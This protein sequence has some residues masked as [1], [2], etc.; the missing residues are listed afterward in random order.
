MNK[1]ILK[2]IIVQND[3]K[4]FDNSVYIDFK[5]K[6]IVTILKKMGI[7]NELIY[8][9]N[10]FAGISINKKIDNNTFQTI[11]ILL[12]SHLN[13]TFNSKIL[14]GKIL[15]YGRNM[16]IY[17]NLK[18]NIFELNDKSYINHDELFYYLISNESILPIVILPETVELLQKSGWY[19]GRKI[20]IEEFIMNYDNELLTDN[21]IYF[22]QEFGGIKGFSVSGQSFE[23]YIDS[24]YNL[25]EKS[26][27]PTKNDM[28]SYEPLNLVGYKEHINFIRIGDFCNLTIK[29]WLSSDGRIFSDQGQQLGRT[30]MEAWQAILLN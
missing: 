3:S 21:Q 10:E 12:P 7:S 4:F 1:N 24:E 9:I 13:D 15:C 14:I 2:D 23:I 27:A 8:F 6:E 11:N 26:K 28:S 19:T 22:M 30:I 20:D 18:S 17:Y 25:Y 5:K 29:L 16:P